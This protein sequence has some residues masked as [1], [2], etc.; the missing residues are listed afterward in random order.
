MDDLDRLFR[1]LVNHL[2]KEAPERLTSP[3]EVSEL[4]QNIVPYRGHRRALKFESVEDYEMAVL[5]LLSGERGYAS[6]EPLDVQEAL[7][8]EAESVNPDPGAFRDF[9]AATVK[10]TAKGIRSVLD[11]EIAYAPP[12]HAPRK[13]GRFAPPE[14]EVA[15]PDELF[16]PPEPEAPAKDRSTEPEPVE[17]PDGRGL[18][19]EAVEATCPHCNVELPGGRRVVYC[20]SCGRQVEE[21]T[22]PACGDALEPG[23]RFCVTCGHSVTG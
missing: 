6:V 20:P 22:C 5:R 11:E 17:P 8:L 2:A 16:A 9:A 18:V 10:L 4:Y 21:A 19:F 23:W 1:Y 14:P 13:D 7:A 12:G 15:T 3:F